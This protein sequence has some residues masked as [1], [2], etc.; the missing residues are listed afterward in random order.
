MI[1][2]AFCGQICALLLLGQMQSALPAAL[3]LAVLQFFING[4]HSLIGGAASM[5]FGG[6]KAAATAAGLFDGMQYV[7]GSVV[8]YG[9]G[10]LLQRHG[11]GVWTWAVLPFAALGAALAGSLWNTL[12]KRGVMPSSSAASSPMIAPK[13]A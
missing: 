12:P 13:G 10:T 8:G 11:W 3:T 9:M 7:A 1:C 2:I 5:D 6:K 4:G